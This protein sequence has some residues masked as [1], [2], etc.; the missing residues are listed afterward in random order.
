MYGNSHPIYAFW[1]VIWELERELLILESKHMQGV[2]LRDVICFTLWY[3]SH[4][5]SSMQTEK[6]WTG[7]NSKKYQ[8]L[9]N[10]HSEIIWTR[11]FLS[12]LLN[13]WFF[14]SCCFK[15]TYIVYFLLVLHFK[16]LYFTWFVLYF[17]HN[18][19]K[20]IIGKMFE[21]IYFWKIKAEMCTC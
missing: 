1:H 13:R 4:L 17:L 7:Q 10:H 5:H 19:L 14:F 11:K 18:G 16:I 2:Q 9:S 12:K 6:T 3:F 20:V 15:V 21:G 8:V